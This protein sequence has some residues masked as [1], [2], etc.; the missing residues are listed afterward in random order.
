MPLGYDAAPIGFEAPPRSTRPGLILA[1]RATA[2]LVAALD[3]WITNL[4]L[5]AIGPGVHERSLSNLSSVL[6]GPRDHL[7]GPAQRST[8]R[9]PGTDA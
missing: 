9:T 3:V 4:G 5:P 6:S 8:S 2:S 1:V 7:S